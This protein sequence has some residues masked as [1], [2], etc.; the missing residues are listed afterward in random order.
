MAALQ[1]PRLTRLQRRKQL[2]DA[3]QRVFVRAGYHAAAMDDIAAEA[4]ISKP[5]LYQHFPGKL[6]LYLALLDLGTGALEAVVRD[7]L[8]STTDNHQ[9][10][11]ATISAYFGVMTDPEGTFRLVFE[12]DLTGEPAVPAP[13][14]SP[15]PS[16]PTPSSTR[17]RRCCWR[18]A[19][20]V[21]RR[22]RPA[23]G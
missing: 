4:G 15:P 9:R 13:T 1:A 6:E 19:S 11:Q 23:G 21:P 3:A 8:A 10:V 18:P 2:L 12:S 17:R 5:V 14:S 20:P 22:C 7:A 16:P